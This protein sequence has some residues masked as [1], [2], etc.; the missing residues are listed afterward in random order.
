MRLS[1]KGGP[2]PHASDVPDG[3][4]PTRAGSKLSRSG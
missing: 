2:E 3:S 1:T 4:L